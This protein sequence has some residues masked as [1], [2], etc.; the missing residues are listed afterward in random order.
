MKEHEFVCQD[1]GQQIEVNEPVQQAILENGCP[2][3]SAP[4]SPDDFS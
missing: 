4:A 3:C 2:V 1:C